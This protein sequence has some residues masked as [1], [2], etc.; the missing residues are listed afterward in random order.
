MQIVSNVKK[1]KSREVVSVELIELMQQS[2]MIYKKATSEKKRQL[3]ELVS[4]NLFLADGTL[5]YEWKEPFKYL[6][7]EDQKKPEASS[8][9]LLEKW[10]G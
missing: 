3:V 9:S 10:G 6:V 1:E 8:G 7:F 5:T 4:S 2:E